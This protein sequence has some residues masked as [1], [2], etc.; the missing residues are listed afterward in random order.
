MTWDVSGGRE[1]FGAAIDRTSKGL[2]AVGSNVSCKVMC[3]SAGRAANVTDMSP[4]VGTSMTTRLDI[5]YDILMTTMCITHVSLLSVQNDFGH[6][7][8]L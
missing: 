2:D 5:S 7:E 8:Q 6:L 1:R 3:P 4:F